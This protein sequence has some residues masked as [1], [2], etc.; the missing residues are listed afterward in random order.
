[1]KLKA[2]AKLNLNLHLIPQ[3]M[4]NGFYPVKF[5]NCELDL[6]DE[7]LLK[8]IKDKIR[9]IADDP[10]L[11][12]QVNN[13]IYKAASLLK[14]YLNNQKL[15]VEI[16]LKKR[17]PIKAG[18]GGGSSDGAATLKALIKLWRAKITDEQ[19]FTIISKLGKDVFYS[20]QGG[21]CEVSGDGS[22]ISKL[23]CKMPRLPIIIVTPIEKK[24]STGFMY[25]LITKSNIGRY[26]KK[27]DNI[28]KALVKGDK[29][30]IIEQL[31]NDFEVTIV[32]QFPI[33]QKI[34]DDLK[35]VG[36][37]NTLVAGSGLSVVGFFKNNTEAQN[38]L[39]ILKINYKNIYYG[40][41]K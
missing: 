36:A 17:I 22:D 39:N 29:K 6:F 1:M 5:I 26:L 8:N 10:E 20:Y 37:L 4:E 40:H 14:K 18:F 28:K 2:W 31:H 24:T 3:K 25:K 19:L 27:I 32:N 41:T 35:K 11:P 30:K 12:D 13:S 9:V 7:I 38:G 15:G 16:N 34:K 23:N 33:V 21:V